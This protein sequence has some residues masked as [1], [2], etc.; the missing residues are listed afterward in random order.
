MIEMLLMFRVAVPLLVSLTV[1]GVL[2]VPITCSGKLNLVGD[3]ETAGR[4]PMPLRATV[5]GL[6]GASS[7]MVTAPLRLPAV[8]GLKVTLRVQ[9]APAATLAPQVLV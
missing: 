4:V 9:L 3:K 5:C 7:V 1:C 2:V 6:L 8:V